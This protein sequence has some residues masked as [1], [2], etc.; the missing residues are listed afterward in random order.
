MPGGTSIVGTGKLAF[1]PTRESHLLESDDYQWLVYRK[2]RIR[3]QNLKRAGLRELTGTPIQPLIQTRYDRF[4]P[5]AQAEI[6]PA[7][8]DHAIAAGATLSQSRAMDL[9][10]Q[11]LEQSSDSSH[12]M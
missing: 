11:G 4:L 2:F 3:L 5:V 1:I 9:A 12:P 10:L 8:W 7:A 6:S